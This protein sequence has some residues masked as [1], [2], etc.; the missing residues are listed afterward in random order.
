VTKGEREMKKGSEIIPSID[1][2]KYLVPTYEHDWQ[3]QGWVKH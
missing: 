3:T 1:Y 2:R